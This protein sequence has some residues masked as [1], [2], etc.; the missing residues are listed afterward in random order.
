ML[1]KGPKVGNF[2]SVKIHE[3]FSK[4]SFNSKAQTHFHKERYCI[5]PHS[6]I[7]ALS[8]KNLTHTQ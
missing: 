2:D 5:Y 3:N 8:K 4:V 7:I 1:L 6:F